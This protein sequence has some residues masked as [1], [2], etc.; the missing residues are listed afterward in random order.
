[1][2]SI[3]DVE[4]VVDGKRLG[5]KEWKHR[6][7][8]YTAE[9]AQPFQIQLPTDNYYKFEP[10]DVP[11]LILSP[12]VQQGLYLYLMPLPPGPHSIHWT[13]TWDCGD[14]PTATTQDITYNL[15]VLPDVAGLIK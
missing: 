12:S 3:R 9:R 4:V 2:D 5:R 13:A 15:K 7:V 6:W 14:P 8:K 10:K 11:E 1:M